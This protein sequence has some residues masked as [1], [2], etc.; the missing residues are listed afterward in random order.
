MRQTPHLVKEGFNF[1][2]VMSDVEGKGAEGIAGF[3]EG[4][5]TLDKY[6]D[7]ELKRSILS[8]RR[9]IRPASGPYL[10]PK[11]IPE[12]VLTDLR[13]AFDRVWADPEFAAEYQRLTKESADPVTGQEIE[14]VLRKM[15]AD[16]KVRE[17]Y[18]QLLGSALLPSIK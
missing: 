13:G 9:G 12:R 3:L 6:A 2:I 11:G 18:T 8:F 16:P 15:P 5:P 17:V 10:A 7:T 1:P 14:R 4:R